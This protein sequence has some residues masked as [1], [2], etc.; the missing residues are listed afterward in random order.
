MAAKKQFFGGS[1]FSPKGS[2][3][4]EFFIPQ[5]FIMFLYSSPQVLC[6]LTLLSVHVCDTMVADRMPGNAG[7]SQLIMDWVWRTHLTLKAYQLHSIWQPPYPQSIIPTK[8][9]SF[10]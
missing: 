5:V 6:F 7:V 2:E 3:N 1:Y 8:R 4:V 10:C 9:R